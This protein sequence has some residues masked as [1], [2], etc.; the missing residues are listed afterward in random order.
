MYSFLAGP[1]TAVITGC[2]IASLSS[3][4]HVHGKITKLESYKSQGL[5]MIENHKTAISS[6]ILSTGI[7]EN[8]ILQIYLNVADHICFVMQI[9]LILQ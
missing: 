3:S 6:R 2:N 1:H 7:L 5:I 8:I 4:L 9:V